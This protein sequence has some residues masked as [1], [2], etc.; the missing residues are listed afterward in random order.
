MKR[1]STPTAIQNRFVDG[2][3]ST[4]QSATQFSAEWCNQIQEEIA[5]LLE[6]NGITLGE[7]ENQ[8]AE[9]FAKVFLEGFLG[10]RISQ[11]RGVANTNITPG[12]VST[13]GGEGI[14]VRV[15]GGLLLN[16][17]GNG[18]F[19]Y[20]SDDNTLLGSLVWDSDAAAFKYTSNLKIDAGK[21]AESDNFKCGRWNL[22][23]DNNADLYLRETDSGTTTTCVKFVKGGASGGSVE[24]LRLINH[25]KPVTFS[26]GAVLPRVVAQ[27]NISL[28]DPQYSVSEGYPVGS[29]IVV[30]NDGSASI[31]VSLTSSDFE[32]IPINSSQMF[33]RRSS[34]SG[35]GGLVDSGWIVLGRRFT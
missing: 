34:G 32:T 19:L 2:N 14:K 33:Y 21:Y 35:S 22:E 8:L 4:G 23:K 9:L 26:K 29:V 18:I 5:G 17:T 13:Y 28:D 1:I 31:D 25:K 20:A 3:K 10:I 24:L 30:E 12:T 27:S 15:Q 16:I 7:S 6:S 11:E